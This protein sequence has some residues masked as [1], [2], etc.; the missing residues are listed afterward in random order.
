MFRL[1]GFRV[2]GQYS[3]SRVVEMVPL[4]LQGLG[5]LGAVMVC[6]EMHHHKYS[7]R[8]GRLL[9]RAF[10]PLQGP[11]CQRLLTARL[12]SLSSV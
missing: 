1:C 4:R 7:G 2:V 9:P 8:F 3:F 11:F 12:G 6:A 5:N 10:Y